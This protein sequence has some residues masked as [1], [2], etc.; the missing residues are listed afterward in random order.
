M[1][2]HNTFFNTLRQHNLVG[3]GLLPQSLSVPCECEACGG[4]MRIVLDEATLDEIAQAIS[5]LHTEAMR[6]Q[7]TMLALKELYLRARQ[8]GACGEDTM[9][10]V[11]DVRD[12]R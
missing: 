9:G 11:F 4:Q 2:N 5:G 10:D 6:V 3:L 7:G 8:L 12:G 1:R